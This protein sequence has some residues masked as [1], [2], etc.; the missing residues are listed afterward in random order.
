MG[1][2]GTTSALIPFP[3]TGIS[4][5]CCSYQLLILQGNKEDAL[6][7]GLSH[8]IQIK[9]G[10]SFAGGNLFFLDVVWICLSLIFRN[11]STHVPLSGLDSQDSQW[12]MVRAP[13]IQGGTL[14]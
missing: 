11:I 2:S 10:I 3:G 12:N 8:V 7:R 4:F 5:H 1:V 14:R 6:K 13:L 9:K